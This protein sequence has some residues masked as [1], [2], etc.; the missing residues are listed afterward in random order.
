MSLM[1]LLLPAAGWAGTGF[2]GRWD[3]GWVGPVAALS[4]AQAGEVHAL[5]VTVTMDCGYM[6]ARV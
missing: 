6:W 5:L 3:N 1:Q 2:A 4:P